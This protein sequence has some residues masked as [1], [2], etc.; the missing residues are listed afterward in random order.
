M[1]PSQLTLQALR[2]L[3]QRQEQ[4]ALQRY[5]EAIVARQAAFEKLESIK[6]QRDQSLA[7]LRDEVIRGAN[8]A[9]VAQAEAYCLSVE[10]LKQECEAEIASS[11]GLV[12]RRWQR[13]VEARR[14]REMLDLLADDL[15]TT[16]TAATA[17]AC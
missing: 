10:S 4:H 6:R 14:Q 9:Q 1:N 2:T 5:G 17:T 12:D 7:F 3:R 16:C 13:L 15:G 8:D 11:Q